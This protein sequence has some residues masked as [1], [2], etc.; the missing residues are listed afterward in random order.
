MWKENDDNGVGSGGTSRN[1]YPLGCGREY[2]QMKLSSEHLFDWY[3]CKID[4]L[5]ELGKDAK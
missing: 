5:I 1:I 4:K 2:L 3:D